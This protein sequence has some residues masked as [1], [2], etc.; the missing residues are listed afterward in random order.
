MGLRGYPIKNSYLS[1]FT[2]N[3]SHVQPWRL[4][5]ECVTSELVS[6]DFLFFIFLNISPDSFHYFIYLMSICIHMAHACDS[7]KKHEGI[8]SLPSY[9]SWGSN[10]GYEAW[11]QAPLPAQILP[12]LF[13][14]YCVVCSS[15]FWPIFTLEISANKAV[16][17]LKNFSKLHSCEI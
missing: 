6:C 15:I 4:V 5:L 1:P 9:R 11:Q 13:L 2:W 8:S 14:L 16:H 17:I 7:Q 3:I 12:T 10:L